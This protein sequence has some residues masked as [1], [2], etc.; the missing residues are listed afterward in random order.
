MNVVWWL[1]ALL[2]ISLAPLLFAQ[3]APRSLADAELSSLVGIYKD[4]HSHPELSGQE[5]RTAALVAKELRAA[6]CPVTEHVGK[7]ENSKL[8]AY[9][10]VGVIK[11]GDRPTVLVRTET[12]A[13]P[14]EAETGLPDASTVVATNDEVKD[15]R[16]TQSGGHGTDI[17]AF[18]G[19]ASARGKLKNQWN[20]TIAFVVQP[21]EEVGTGARAR[22]NDGL[23][24][25][26]GKP[27]FALGF[28]DKADLHTG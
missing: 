21:A 25:R 11:N 19:T 9:G 10:V 28:H 17:A 2:S 24:D 4:I 23:Y 7:Y 18:T 22:L 20:G 16:V 12:G 8:K 5:E 14:V 3:Q 6:G 26:F 13:L 1:I 15:V 27:D